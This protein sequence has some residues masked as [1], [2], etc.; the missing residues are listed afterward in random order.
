MVLDYYRK[1]ISEKSFKT[2]SPCSPCFLPLSSVFSLFLSLSFALSVLPN[3]AGGEKHCGTK[4]QF[5]PSLA[6][7]VFTRTLFPSAHLKT[8]I[9]LT[10]KESFAVHLNRLWLSTTALSS[11]RSVPI[12]RF[13]ICWNNQLASPLIIQVMQTVLQ[14][15]LSEIIGDGTWRERGILKNGQRWV[16]GY[17]NWA[18]SVSELRAV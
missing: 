15:G 6:K 18:P 12:G 7:N 8:I 17:A 3:A 16:K 9:W 1:E 14:M 5:D 4:N 10:K 2:L 13:N 11:L